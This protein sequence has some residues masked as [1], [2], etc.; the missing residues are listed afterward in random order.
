MLLIYLSVCHDRSHV[1]GDSVAV[2]MHIAVAVSI[3]KQQ[4]PGIDCNMLRLTCFLWRLASFSTAFASRKTRRK[5]PFE[6]LTASPLCVTSIHLECMRRQKTTNLSSWVLDPSAA[7]CVQFTARFRTCGI[8]KPFSLVA[9][10][11]PGTL[12]L[13]STN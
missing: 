13:S 4:A 10:D 7:A 8:S 3:Y 5:L 12:A 2:A 9:R 6:R 1:V 11:S